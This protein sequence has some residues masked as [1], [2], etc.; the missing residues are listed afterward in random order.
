[1]TREKRGGEGQR[2]ERWKGKGGLAGGVIEG[3]GW[4]SGRS[5]RGERKDHWASEV[6]NW[7]L[8]RTESERKDE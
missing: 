8:G 3:E 6:G 4:M 2:A 1:M 5:D 7:R